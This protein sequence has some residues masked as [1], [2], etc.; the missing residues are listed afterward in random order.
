MTVA[1][2][3][4]DPL[5]VAEAGDMI[6]NS[7]TR[8]VVLAGMASSGKTTLIS[9]LY[10]SFLNGPLGAYMM[11]GCQTLSGFE[12]RCHLARTASN[13]DA[14]DTE[15]TRPDEQ[16]LYLHLK[17]S[18]TE[19]SQLTREVLVA[20]WWGE[21]FRQVKD[22]VDFVR[23][24]SVL[25]SCTN[26][27]ILIDGEKI[28]SNNERQIARSDA[29]MVLRSCL[30]SEMLPEQARVEVVFTKADLFRR[31]QNRTDSG[32]IKA[33]NEQFENNF[34]NRVAR[35]SFVETAARLAGPESTVEKG[36]GIAELL[37]LWVEQ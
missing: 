13:A 32:F 24:L 14:P 30:D 15:R 11:A 9:S 34:A 1:L 3:T 2:A 7:L 31:K 26:L 19:P 37:K 27:T 5:T 20:D 35:L 22:S 33:T 10:E 29:L 25:N 28:A 16:D 12:K 8:V 36:H 6:A 18:R 23:G 17:L 21:T 4:G